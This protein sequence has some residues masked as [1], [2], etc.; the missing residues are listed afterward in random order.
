MKKTI[1]LFL[2]ILPVIIVVLVFAIAGVV[3]RR[4]MVVPVESVEI[5]RAI[6]EDSPQKHSPWHEQYGTNNLILIVSPGEEIEFARYFVI[7]PAEASLNFSLF[8]ISNPEV[9][10]IN[11]QGNIV[12]LQNMRSTD[13]REGIEIVVVDGA[14]RFFSVFI[15]IDVDGTRFDYFGFDGD[16]FREGIGRDWEEFG[17]ENA[18]DFVSID[19]EN[20]LI[21]ERNFI[22]YELEYVIPIAAI[23]ERGFNVAPFD[24]LYVINPLREQFLASLTFSSSNNNILR[25]TGDGFAEVL[26]TGEMEIRI[27]TNFLNSNFEIVVNIVIM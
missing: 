16:L 10:Q 5:N 21:I 15:I 11:E 26:G 8:E 7:Y 13:P 20:Q 24:L 3:G 17:L 9:V 2:F 12:V 27:T 1:L 14:T 19:F 18:G 23:L 6:F 22:P 4:Q 25:I